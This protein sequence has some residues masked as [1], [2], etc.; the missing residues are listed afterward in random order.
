[1]TTPTPISLITPGNP[2]GMEPS[3]NYDL[4]P[5]FVWFSNLNEYTFKLFELNEQTGNTQTQEDI[6]NLAPY[7]QQEVNTTSF[8]Y[9][10]SAPPLEYGNTYAWQ[11][12]AQIVSPLSSNEEEY[13]S[14]VY[15]F[16]ISGGEEANPD[17]LLLIN[18]LRQLNSPS[19]EEAINLFG[20]GY[21]LKSLKFNDADISV[22][23]LN[24]ILLRLANGEIH[25]KSIT[26][27]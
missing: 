12:T 7:Y 2:V 8:T 23:D 26:I 3:V 15:T 5:N 14:N 11:V 1:V 22:N 25:L 4:N 20:N 27:E 21:S 24:N 16:K 6:E 17:D 9:P 13:K 18:F 10:T 19:G